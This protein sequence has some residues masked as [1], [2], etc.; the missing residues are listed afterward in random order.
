M[1]YIISLVY[2]EQVANDRKADC[3]FGRVIK[4]HVFSS[5]LCSKF[6]G[7]AQWKLR[8][9]MEHVRDIVVTFKRV[10]VKI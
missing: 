7:I 3:L 8:T 9:R 2:I 4:R 6:V 5:D 1:L 10:F